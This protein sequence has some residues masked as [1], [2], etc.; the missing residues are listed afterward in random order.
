MDLLDIRNRLRVLQDIKSQENRNRKNKSNV[1]CRIFRGNIHQY[2]V[3]KLLENFTT[4]TVEKMP[5]ESSV[6]VAKR[7]CH[8]ISSIYREAPNR[9]F[10]DITDD[11][12]NKLHSIYSDMM[13]NSKLLHS[14]E[15]FTLQRQVML[16]VIPMGGQ[17]KLRVM[18]PHHYDVIPDPYGDPEEP[19]AVIISAYDN[20]YKENAHLDKTFYKQSPDSN[21]D[22]IT[23]GDGVDQVIA[24][25]D[26][27]KAMKERYVVW[28]KKHMM[29]DG[30]ECPALNFVMD[31]K[32]RILSAD[33]YSKID[34]LPFIDISGNK[35]FQ[36]WVDEDS[37]L[38]SFT[39]KINALL[40]EMQVNIRF[41]SWSQAYLKASEKY[42]HSIKDIE[43]GPAKIIFLPVDGDE[44]GIDP[45]FGFANPGGDL[46]VGLEYIQS[47]LSAFLTSNGLDPDVIS[48]DGNS[49]IYNSGFERFLA[50]LQRFSASKQDY[51]LYRLVENKLLDLVK[52][53]HNA[54]KEHGLLDQKYLTDNFTDKENVSIKYVQPEAVQTKAEQIAYQ[55]AVIESGLGSKITAIMKLENMTRPQAMS[56]LK[57]VQADELSNI[58]KERQVDRDNE[59]R[60]FKI[61]EEK[62][63]DEE[64]ESPVQ[65][66][67][68]KMIE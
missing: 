42:L 21:P 63:K 49:K 40:S 28:T 44:P 57:Q 15:Y 30:T 53:W 12:R 18:N 7:M 20:D 59:E 19:L 23:R 14:N 35:N 2:V 41:Q 39:V 38:A 24:D 6:N 54:G 64:K 26:D 29:P 1:E 58:I 34:R 11:Q 13:A 56:Y 62:D 36:Y 32:G 66:L 3:E 25:E 10:M 8:E 37:G 31:G 45:E 68:E 67:S 46:R 65:I 27:Y 48:N 22:E 52:T 47:I 5:I 55:Q 4:A 43:V 60:E 16:Q 61:L 9:E 50:Q 51:D 17:L 33:P